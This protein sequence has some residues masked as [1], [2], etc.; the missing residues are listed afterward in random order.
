MKINVNPL[1]IITGKDGQLSI[2]R[3]ISLAAF[4]KVA[5]IIDC[6][7]CTSEY[8]YTL[9]GLVL[10]PLGLTTWQNTKPNPESGSE[11]N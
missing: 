11:V 6:S 8:L 2:R 4:V 7:T 1:Y 5:F 10:I 3:I 9:A